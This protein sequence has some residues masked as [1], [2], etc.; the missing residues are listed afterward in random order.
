MMNGLEYD[1]SFRCV[2]RVCAY[3]CVNSVI[4]RINAYK[5]LTRGL[6]NTFIRFVLAL[7]LDLREGERIFDL[8]WHNRGQLC[9]GVGVGVCM[10]V[11]CLC[12]CV[13]GS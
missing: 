7:G 9:V 2:V 1:A 3:A 12:L 6:V 5:S 8:G 13:C 11:A 10:C 4:V